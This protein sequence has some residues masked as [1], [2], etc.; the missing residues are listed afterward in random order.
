MSALETAVF[1]TEYV[2][3]YGN[4]THMTSPAVDLNFYQCF[5][6]DII[7]FILSTCL[8]LVYLAFQIKKCTR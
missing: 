8:F 1:W 6:L 2:I 4:E 3:R 5:S 7:G